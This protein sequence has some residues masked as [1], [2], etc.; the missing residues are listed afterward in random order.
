MNPLTL[1]YYAMRAMIKIPQLLLVFMWRVV[2]GHDDAVVILQR[3]LPKQLFLLSPVVYVALM[4]IALVTLLMTGAID[5]IVLQFVISIVCNV[6]IFVTIS[7][8]LQ[9]HDT[10]LIQAQ[11]IQY[12]LIFVGF[13]QT[14]VWVI[15]PENPRNEP[16]SVFILFLATSVSFV[17]EKVIKPNIERVQF[18]PVN[19][20]N[21]EYGSET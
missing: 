14:V 8:G 10:R 4:V 12:Y 1:V 6:W 17:N 5:S 3:E 15:H 19:E 20:L 18:V 9:S 16:S 21:Q 2:R 7:L 13:I 11:S